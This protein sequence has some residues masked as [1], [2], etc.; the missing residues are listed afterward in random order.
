MSLN[1][2]VCQGRIQPERSGGHYLSAEGHGSGCGKGLP[3]RCGSS[4]VATLEKYI[5][6]A[7]TCILVRG[8]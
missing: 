7:K 3:S 4:G 8:F 6:N 5:Y 2:F 1:K